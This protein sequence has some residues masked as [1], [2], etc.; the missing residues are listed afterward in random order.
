MNQRALSL[1]HRF[2]HGLQ[3]L[4]NV[5]AG[6]AAFDH[7]N[8]TAQMPFGSLETL[9]YVGMR[10]VAVIGDS[11]FP[12]LPRGYYQILAIDLPLPCLNQPIIRLGIMEYRIVTV[13][14]MMI[15][16]LALAVLGFRAPVTDASGMVQPATVTSDHQGHAHDHHGHSHDD[17]GELSAPFGH[18]HD[19]LHVGDHSHDTPTAAVLIGLRFASPKDPGLG[20][21][22]GLVA[23]LPTSPGDR[24]PQVA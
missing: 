2:L 7:R 10:A 20:M 15:C 17:E 1:R 11:P 24:P 13:R 21:P 9:D 4:S 19:R 23:S 3:L 8:D 12:I 16:L 14:T 18:D 6:L 5:E 22:D